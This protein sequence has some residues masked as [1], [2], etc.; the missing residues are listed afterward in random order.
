LEIKMIIPKRACTKPIVAIVLS[1]L[2]FF[3]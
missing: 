1:T 2:N 3:N